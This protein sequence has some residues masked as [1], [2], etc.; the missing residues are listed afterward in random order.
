MNALR[1]YMRI[2]LILTSFR[3]PQRQRQQQQ[4]QQYVKDKERKSREHKSFELHKIPSNAT[5]LQEFS[6]NRLNALISLLQRTKWKPAIGIMDNG[7]LE[8]ILEVLNATSFWKAE[9]VAHCALECLHLLTLAPFVHVPLCELQLDSG[10]TGIGLIFEASSGSHEPYVVMAALEV[11]CN[12]VTFHALPSTV[13]ENFQFPAYIQ[14]IWSLVRYN[15]GIRL[16]LDLLRYSVPS[17]ADAV[18]ALACKAILGLA[19]DAQ[20]NQIL[21]KMHLGSLI[22]DLLKEPVNPEHANEFS[23]FKEYALE[24]L[25]IT[26]G[27]EAHTVSV[28]ARDHTVVRLE[29]AAIVS[30]TPISY[31]S[32]ELLQLIHEYLVN[33]SL[34][35]TADKLLSESVRE[36]YCFFFLHSRF[37]VHVELTSQSISPTPQRIQPIPSF[38]KQTDEAAVAPTK[39]MT[40]DQMP[41]PPP[42]PSTVPPPLLSRIVTQYLRQQ[43]RECE[44][45]I[46][47]L[48]P[49]SLL[50]RHRCPKVCTVF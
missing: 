38:M 22:T 4:Q 6:K 43:H 3:L 49:F 47:V 24:L 16:L 35:E 18:R 25:S 7:G 2:H 23:K 32:T 40:M 1:S 15:D 21:R 31:N 34:H 20:I 26:T 50:S 27:R 37:K 30:N 12:L 11:I 41:P 45:P 13:I 39:S 19:Q 8:L 9:H 29:K 36:Y 10:N 33:N 48:P 17:H 46:S 44:D 28:E 14:R 5:L 42:P